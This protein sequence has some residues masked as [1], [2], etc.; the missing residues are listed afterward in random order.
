MHAWQRSVCRA[1]GGCRAAQG[2]LLSEDVTAANWPDHRVRKL[3]V[4]T[5][6]DQWMCAYGS[7][8]PPDSVDNERSERV[9]LAEILAARAIPFIAS[10]GIL[11]VPRISF[12][13][14]YER[15]PRSSFRA[16]APRSGFPSAPGRENL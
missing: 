15:A 2:I 10:S 6:K 8:N 9:C 4:E 3:M 14:R 16:F 7:K 11:A 13:A 12:V 1:S 5:S